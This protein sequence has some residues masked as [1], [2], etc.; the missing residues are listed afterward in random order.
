[1]PAPG[2]DLAARAAK[3]ILVVDDDHDIRESLAEVLGELGYD[4]AIA[5]NG[6][7]A[8]DE[9][10]RAP[11]AAVLLDLMMPVMDGWQFRDAQR[12][13]PALAAVPVIV[14]SADGNVATSAASLQARAFLRKP[15]HIND[16]LA[17]LDDL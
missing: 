6:R 3:R 5:G 14:I 11:T 17:L 7:E 16:L 2:P 1:M 9:L 4:V 12:R 10:G 13:T 15:I 8:L